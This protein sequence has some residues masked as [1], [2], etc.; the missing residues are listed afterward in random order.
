VAVAGG[1]PELVMKDVAWATL[2][3]D[4]KALAF[5]HPK[6]P[7]SVWIS[8]PVGAPPRKYLSSPFEK[9]QFFSVPQVHFSPD[10]SKILLYILGVAAGG[11]K[12]GHEWWLIPYPE[13]HAPRRVF[14]A[15]PPPVNIPTFSWMPDSRHVVISIGLDRERDNH[16]WMADT[17]SNAYNLMTSGPDYEIWPAVSPDGQKLIFVDWRTDYDLVEVPL[18]GGPPQALIATSR[19]ESTP[20]WSPVAQQFVYVTDRNGPLEI[21]LK[22]AQDGW[23][24]PLVTP[25]QF[26]DPTE[27]FWGPTFSPDGSRIAYVRIS[28]PGVVWIWISSSSGGTSVRLT[29]EPATV[30]E[31]P[32]TW[33]PD[34]NW[35]AYLRVQGGKESLVK[36]KLGGAEAPVVLKQNADDYVPAWSPTGAWITFR[37]EKGEWLLVSPDGKR[38]RSLGVLKSDYL[39][40]SRDGK[41]LYGIHPDHDHHQVL[42][43]LDMISARQKEI[44]D[45]GTEFV[46]G[47]YYVPAVRFS[48]APDG[49]SFAM[50]IV[51]SRQDLWMLEGFNSRGGWLWK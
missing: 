4:G 5:L 50:S 16:L 18:G 14:Q 40:W 32:P 51:K 11:E 21:W 2:S 42:F 17:Q 25:E 20:S 31:N 30:G 22:S 9:I 41:T 48:L 6:G 35:L 28:P 44:T 43:S 29:R 39:L 26:S 47:A 13:G 33:S 24:R 15:L 3:P 10:G 37:T 46:P 19:W 49:R 27:G 12:P 34:G 23:S 45:L 8:S 36:F 1:E 38:E 7:S